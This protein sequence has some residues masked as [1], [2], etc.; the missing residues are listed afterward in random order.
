MGE[1]GQGGFGRLRKISPSPE[2]DPQTVQPKA[3]RRG[4]QYIN[5]Y[6][7]IYIYII[8]AG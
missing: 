4:K 1:G 8:W 6:I 7:Y 3:S 2:F 5:I